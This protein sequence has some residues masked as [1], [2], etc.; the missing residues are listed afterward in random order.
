[1]LQSCRCLFIFIMIELS[2]TWNYFDC[3]FVLDKVYV[4]NHYKQLIPYIVMSYSLKT[5]FTFDYLPLSAYH[6]R[7]KWER[8]SA[9][10]KVSVVNLIVWNKS[11]WNWIASR[12][13]KRIC[14]HI[15]DMVNCD[16]TTETV[17]VIFFSISEKH[18][19]S[20]NT[21]FYDFFF[22]HSWLT[23]GSP[24]NAILYHASNPA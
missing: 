8:Y 12:V 2:I 22:Y 17:V 16:K 15:V 11:T 18:R 10:E 21:F 5:L 7:H 9:P 13:L 20:S 14:E 24:N 23:G 4:L 1:M 6:V 19:P 3:D